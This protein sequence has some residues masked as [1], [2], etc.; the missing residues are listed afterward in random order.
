MNCIKGAHMSPTKYV[1]YCENTVDDDGNHRDAT[2][3]VMFRKVGDLS[4]YWMVIE[5]STVNDSISWQTMPTQEPPFTPD[6]G[7]GEDWF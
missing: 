2:M 5:H 4:P 1:T 3:P 6:K 7:E